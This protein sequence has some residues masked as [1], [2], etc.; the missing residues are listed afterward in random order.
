MSTLPTSCYEF[1]SFRLDASRS[2]LLRDG[3]QVPVSPKALETLLLLVSEAG[4]VLRKE[5]F[6]ARI[7]PDCFVEEQNLTQYIFTLRKALGEAPNDHRYI[8]TVPGQGY[9]FVAPVRELAETDD[10]QAKGARTGEARAPEESVA[11]AASIAVLPFKM[12]GG[13][14]VDDFLGPGLADALITRLG[15]VGQISVCSTSAV[16]RYINSDRSPLAAG[17]E[18]GVETVLDGHLQR[19]GERI[20]LTVQLFRLSDGKT[21]W[22]EK[23]DEKFTDVFSVQDSISEQVVRAL[24][25]K[26][27]DEE[28][29]SLTKRH[30]GDAEA[31]QAYIRGRYFWNRRTAEGLHKAIGYF[32]QAI[33]ID[34]A[35][36][37]AFV[38]LAD[39]Y[40]LLAG[41]G[42]L[43]PQE[44]FPKAKAAAERALEID[45]SLA[46]AFASLGFVSYRF[47]WNWSDSER[48]FKRAIAMKP[49]YA[50]AHHWYGESLA[51]AGRFDDSLAELGRAQELDP[52]SLPINTDLGQSLYFA[53]RYE[54]AAVQL[55]K[56]LEM[57]AD[58]PR[59]LIILSAVYEQQGRYME[60]IELA[61]RAVKLSQANPLALSGLGHA[62]ALAG[63]HHEARRIVSDLRRLAANRYVSS[64]NIALV[65]AGLGEHSA[66]L[67]YLEEAVGNSD[68][69]LVWLKFNPRLDI[70]CDDPRFIALTRRV[71]L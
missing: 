4:R 12:L 24:V 32:E 43:H 26:L 17:H 7:W 54:E 35:Y 19:S 64:Y 61:C 18:L 53:R 16:L 31:F 44:T 59:A 41:H 50:T 51:A 14:Q 63:Q 49:N 25:R 1:G 5:E 52:L 47:D 15:G 20:R 34:P 71:N 45:G 9:R 3:E 2:L 66:A 70:L 36:A 67:D 46:E 29:Q 33:A 42:G 37:L 62:R 10:A 30:T 27:T 55:E 56:T 68:V 23:F 6:I 58:F 21:L 8:V 38:G 57:D 65:Y 22:A 13:D 28:L 60:A 48:H 11:P 40:N 69:W 39:A